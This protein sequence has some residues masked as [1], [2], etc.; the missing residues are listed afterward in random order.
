MEREKQKIVATQI[1]IGED[2][3]NE[4]KRESDRLNIPLNAALITMPD[5]G[6]KYRELVTKLLCSHADKSSCEP[7]GIP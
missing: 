4:A 6:L 3:Y 5:D 1:R 2:L 7:D